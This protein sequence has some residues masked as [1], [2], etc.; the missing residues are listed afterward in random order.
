MSLKLA[1]NKAEVVP[2]EDAGVTVTETV[3]F[4]LL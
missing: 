1:A 4:A 3:S 2:P